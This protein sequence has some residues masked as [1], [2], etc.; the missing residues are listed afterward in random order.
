MGDPHP[1]HDDDRVLSSASPNLRLRQRRSPLSHA[2]RSPDLQPIRWNLRLR[3]RDADDDADACCSA[4][5]HLQRPLVQA[6]RWHA[7]GAYHRF[8]RSAWSC[9]RDRPHR[10]LEILRLHPIVPYDDDDG[11]TNQRTS[12]RLDDRSLASWMTKRWT[13]DAV[14]APEAPRSPVSRSRRGS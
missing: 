10:A 8:D 13:S 9:L 6:Y 14:A 1:I 2:V 5:N 3:V 7:A 12:S 4:A 11:G